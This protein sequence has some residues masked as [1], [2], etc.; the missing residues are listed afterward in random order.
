MKE[1][2]KK[3][4]CII[5]GIVCLVSIFALFVT[6]I[7]AYLGVFT[8]PSARRKMLRYHSD[9]AYDVSVKGVFANSSHND[10]EGSAHLRVTVDLE[11]YLSEYGEEMFQKLQSEYFG[12]ETCGFWLTPEN[13]RILCENGFYDIIEEGIELE[14]IVSARIWWDGG[15]Y[16]IYEVKIG[17]T[18][19][20]DYE[21]GKANHLH[22]IEYE[23]K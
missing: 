23:M 5:G 7:L 15:I 22:W 4:V 14:I 3:I 8:F 19:Y 16:P 20:L 6:I 1:I 12:S 11:A 18:V 2:G 10:R 13:N 21:V 17:D 9:P